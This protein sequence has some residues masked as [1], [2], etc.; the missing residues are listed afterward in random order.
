MK[1]TIKMAFLFIFFSYSLLWVLDSCFDLKNK[2]KTELTYKN[3]ME[4]EIEVDEF[5]LTK[6]GL[7]FTKNEKKY[8]TK[9][10]KVLIDTFIEMNPTLKK[11]YPPPKC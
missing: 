1:R 3:E 6:I 11:Y 4:K 2:N 8:F 9:N 10:P 7:F 5:W